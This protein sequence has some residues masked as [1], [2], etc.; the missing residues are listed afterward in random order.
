MKTLGGTVPRSRHTQRTSA[1]APMISPVPSSTIG[2]YSSRN[3]SRSIAARRSAST[4]S[5]SSAA[6]CISR[7][8]EHMHALAARLGHVHR[9]VGVAHQF[10]RASPRACVRAIPMLALTNT[11]F[12]PS[13]NGRARA[14]AMR[15]AIS[16]TSSHARR[17]LDQ[18]GKLVAAQPRDEVAVAHAGAQSTGRFDEQAIAS[19]MAERVVDRL[20][21][22]EVEEQH[23]HRLLVPCRRGPA[24]A[25]P[26]TGRASGSRDR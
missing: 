1:S 22:V 7:F 12:P 13:L 11:S 14:A 16:R 18:H 3:S 25:R 24:H 5:R 2:W 8:E 17:I 9:H 10:V 19:G 15:S 6:V 26:D 23:R 4:T 21:V 20:E